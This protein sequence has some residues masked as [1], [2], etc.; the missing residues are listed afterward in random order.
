[1]AETKTSSGT[2]ELTYLEAVNAALFRALEETPETIV[3]GEDV[4][5]PGGVFGATRGLREKFGDRVFDT[6]ISESAIVGAAIGSAIMGCRPVAEIMWIDFSLVAMDQIVNQASNVRYVS[7]GR[8][9]APMTI[10]TQHGV[11]SGSCA[12]HS[13]SLEAIFAHVPGLLVG[14]PATA[15]DAYDMLLAAIYADDPTIVIENRGLYFGPK[16]EVRLDADIQ[17]V[18]GARI[19]KEGSDATLISWGRMLH[20]AMEAAELLD[21][22]GIEVELI[23][24]RWLLP[25]DAATVL[26][27]VEKTHRAVIAHEANVSGGFGAEVAARIADEGLF[28]LDA[29]VCRVGVPDCRIP[30][31]PGLQDALIPNVQSIARA[32][33]KVMHMEE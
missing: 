10:R 28:S 32:I 15:Q 30:A 6:P 21:G 18:E 20:T 11:L 1:M 2:K 23:D 19:V 9:H 17:K 26:A 13:Q 24:A 14:M 8:L 16:Q 3:F 7:N 5:K 31:A 25:F 27:S 12:Q 33:R 4:A 22:E 29:P